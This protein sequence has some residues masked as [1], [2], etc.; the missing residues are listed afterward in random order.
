MDAVLNA[1]GL[2]GVAPSSMTA[3]GTVQCG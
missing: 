3:S 2:H 1:L